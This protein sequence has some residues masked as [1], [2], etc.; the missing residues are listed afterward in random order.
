MAGSLFHSVMAVIFWTAAEAAD[1]TK[2][3]AKTHSFKKVQEVL[4]CKNKS[5]LNILE[6]NI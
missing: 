1:H 2:V 5:G 4:G 6:E 3:S